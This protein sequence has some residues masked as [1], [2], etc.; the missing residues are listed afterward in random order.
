MIRNIVAAT[1]LLVVGACASTTPS[2]PGA[3]R[4]C[5]RTADVT[6]YGIQ[7]EHRVR[8]SVGSS[9]HYYLSI[10]ENTRDLDWTHA[11]RLQSS[12]SFVCV[13]D[14]AS[15]AQIIGGEPVRWY[16]VRSI[17]RAPDDTPQGS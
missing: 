10:D 11:L 2:E 6:G 17:E 16:L 1:A 5:F 13:G 15:G 9:R 4:D 3:S 7:D 12:T 8:V 14:I